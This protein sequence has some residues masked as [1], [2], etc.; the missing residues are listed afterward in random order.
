MS[1][2]D[3][4]LVGEYP[5]PE[6]DSHQREGSGPGSP[7]SPHFFG[8]NKKRETERQTDTEVARKEWPASQKLSPWPKAQAEEVVVAS[9]APSPTPGAR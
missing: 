8:R 6:A 2:I 7:F 1:R 3:E 9:R 5:G 4:K